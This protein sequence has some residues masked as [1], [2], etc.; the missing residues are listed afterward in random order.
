M[1]WR[2]EL[3]EEHSGLRPYLV[4]GSFAG[5]SNYLSRNLGKRRL[6][7]CDAKQISFRSSKWLA[8]PRAGD[9]LRF[10]IDM[11]VVLSAALQTSGLLCLP[12][13][14]FSYFHPNVTFHLPG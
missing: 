1:E 9:P 4:L 7:G 3:A 13:T 10:L 8:G 11:N 6:A 12:K 14:P 2:R 5:P